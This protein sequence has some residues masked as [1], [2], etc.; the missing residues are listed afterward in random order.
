MK[1][2]IMIVDDEPNVRSSIKLFL[3]DRYYIIEAENGEEALNLLKKFNIDLILL[4][5]RMEDMDGIDVLQRIKKEE[6]D[7]NVI[8]VT[9]E[10]DVKKVVDAMK[11][12]A[13]DYITKPFNESEL[14]ISMERALEN[15]EL[16]QT[17]L[18]LESE[19]ENRWKSYE[20]VGK[21]NAMIDVFNTI[22]KVSEF[23]TNILI[24][25]ETGVGK[26][27]VARAIHKKCPRSNKP[28]VA[29]NCGAM[30]VNLIESE[31]FGHESG[32]FTGATYR[33]KGKF[34]LAHSG[35][36]FLDEISELSKEAQ[37]KLLRVLQSGEFTRLGGNQTLY[38]DII[39]FAATNQNLEKLVQMNKFR[40]DLYYRIKVFEIEVPPLRN[41]KEDIPLLVNHFIKKHSKLMNIKEKEISKE[42]S[43]RLQN[44]YD[45]EGNI[46][47]L[48]NKVI[49]A[50]ILSQGEQLEFNDFFPP[51][52]DKMDF[53]DITPYFINQVYSIGFNRE[54][55]ENLRKKI[56]SEILKTFDRIFIERI[57]KKVGGNVQKAVDRTG[58]N[59]TYFYFLLKRSDMKIEDF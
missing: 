1:H 53:T 18:Y 19:L 41:R 44:T 55:F 21:S 23:N 14:L 17:N 13:Y 2:R 57:L 52:K 48:E 34:E 22:D 4:D 51:K 37:V 58:I 8:M 33:K 59:R 56:K 50:L 27:L 38:T 3:E 16:K 12:G 40:K 5:I 24:T 11:L 45:W 7:L 20:M 42:V 49:S 28:F 47:E 31:L 6:P 43:I 46:R 9:V 35:I 25:G 54:E 26:E 29:I 39:I 15:I 36:V 10:Q 32:A 30:P